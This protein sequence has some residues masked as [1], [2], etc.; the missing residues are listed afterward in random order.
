MENKIGD[1]K[2]F[3]WKDFDSNSIAK[4]WLN[5]HLA[6]IKSYVLEIIFPQPL[7]LQIAIKSFE[8]YQ[9]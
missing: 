5:S 2:N 6:Y 3:S 1:I 8:I 9:R 7:F 4:I